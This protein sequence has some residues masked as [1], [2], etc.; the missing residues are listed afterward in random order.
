MPDYIP[1][2]AAANERQRRY[3]QRLAGLLAPV[4]RC[5]DCGCQAMAADPD[6]AEPRCCRCWR[7]TDEG[8][9]WNRARMRTARLACRIVSD[10]AA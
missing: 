10:G 5:V 4:P 7:R 8:R 6:E 2:R 3:K 9:E 1:D